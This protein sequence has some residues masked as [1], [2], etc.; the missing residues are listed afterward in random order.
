[1]GV[2]VRADVHATVL[3]RPRFSSKA[4]DAGSVVGLKLCWVEATASTQSFGV[5]WAPRTLCSKMPHVR[6][7]AQVFLQHLEVDWQ[8][9]WVAVCLECLK[10]SLGF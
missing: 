5:F 4:A 3:S 2:S 9:A 6:Q 10:H 8:H 7:R 1:M